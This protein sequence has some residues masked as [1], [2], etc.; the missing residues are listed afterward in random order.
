MSAVP[1]PRQAGPPGGHRDP[2][3]KLLH[4]EACLGNGVEYEKTTGLERYDFVNEAAPELALHRIDTSATLIGKPLRVPL[5]ISPM[6]GG[7]PRGLELNRR[8]AAVAQ[9]FG[10]AMGVLFDAF[11]VRMVI[12]PSLMHLV[13][14]K[15]WWLPAWLDRILPNVDVE[16]AAL[17]REHP[18]PHAD[19]AQEAEAAKA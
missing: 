5:M 18:V 17:E 14:E 10:L 12:V 4:I 7:T 6:T 2:G 1:D 19:E 13:G 8:L 16:G 3:S 15:A 11:V 9:R